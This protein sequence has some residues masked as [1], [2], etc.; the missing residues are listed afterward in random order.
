MC[1][2]LPV[3]GKKVIEHRISLSGVEREQLE[4]FV[5]GVNF[6]NVMT[7]VVDLLSDVSAMAFLISML[8]L[9]GLTDFTG[10]DEWARDVTNGAFDKTGDAIDAG[11]AAAQSLED[12]AEMIQETV[13]R[14]QSFPT[15]LWVA[16]N[17]QVTKLGGAVFG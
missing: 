10:M 13:N 6:R 4:N 12:T 17:I 8:E 1:P 15:R 11:I 7:P 3:D 14:V 9:T 16:L 2:R 5:M